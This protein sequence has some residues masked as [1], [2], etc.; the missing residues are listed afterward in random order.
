[1]SIPSA[2]P[3]V[4]DFYGTALVLER[5]SDQL[6]SDAGLLPLRHFDQRIGHRAAFSAAFD[7]LCDPDLGKHSS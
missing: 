6:A 2:G 5:S 4:L 1:M 7:N 3:Q